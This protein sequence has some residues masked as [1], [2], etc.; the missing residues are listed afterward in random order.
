MI[1]IDKLKMALSFSRGLEQTLFDR[2]MKASN[3]IPIRYFATPEIFCTKNNELG[4]VIRVIGIPF[5]VQAGDELNHAQAT[6]SFV[7]QNLGDEFAVYVTQHRRR[8]MCQLEGEYPSGFARDFV[9]AYSAQFQQAHLF[10]NEIYIT[11]LLKAGSTRIKKGLAWLTQLNARQEQ[12][13][14]QAW[15]E[16]RL[17]KFKT[18]LLNLATALK[19]YSPHILAQR[20]NEGGLP[21]AELL[22][23][24]SILVNG[25]KKAF[26]YPYADIASFIPN[27]RLFFGDNTL[28]FQHPVKGHDR[29]G[30]LLSIKHYCPFTKPGLLNA[31][32]TTPFETITT[33][34][35]M[36]IDKQHALNLIETQIKRLIATQDA[37]RSQIA[38][39]ETA[40]DDLASGKISYGFHH[41]TVLIL[42][43]SLEDLEDKVSHVI[44]LYQDNRIAVV[45]E[46]L[47][48]EKAFWAQIPGNFKDIKRKAPISSHNFSC[49]CALHNYHTGYRD[50][51]HLGGALM[52][53]ETMSKTPFYFNLH[54]KASGRRDDLPEG[55]TVLI[56]PTN[57]GKTVIMSTIN[58]LMQKYQI[59]SF[60]FDRNYG[61]EIYVRA[62]GGVYHRLE[63]G[64]PTGWNPCQLTDTPKNRQF[65][66]DFLHVLSTGETTVLTPTDMNQIADV[67]D[68]IFTLPLDKRNLSNVASFFRLDF[69]GLTSLSRYLRLPDR[70]GRRGDRAYLFD[71]D[72]DHLNVNAQTMGFDMTHWLTE[73]GQ[74]PEALLPISMYLFHRIDA[75]L[76]GQLTG[77]YLDEG[78]QF[79]NQPYWKE[80]LEEYLVTWRKRNAFL[81]FAT[82]LPDKVA[83]SALAS[84]LIQNTATKIFLANP[85][86]KEKDYVGSFELTPR[87]YEIIKH[88]VPQSRYFLIK[89]GHEAAVARINLQGLE[90]HMTVLSGTDHTV[91][92]CE[93]ARQAKGEDPTLWLPYFY[94]RR[95]YA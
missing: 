57:A 91:R 80:K 19:S 27:V 13:Q 95:G 40:K 87:E 33:H 77:L 82:Q 64:I 94:E 3:Y 45:R 24:L 6:L 88:L 18:A 43:D 89:Q 47:N 56:G 17:R 22:S 68:R 84:A 81:F 65:L 10:V 39:L 72:V 61:M 42:S 46:T 31:L 59:R 78:W 4:A 74:P 14:Q 34:S 23:F 26:T 51:N 7:L 9:N 54:K 85:Q 15:L 86:A 69:G 29:F 79:L 20:P 32:L 28:H 49:F 83:N 30:A 16:Q 73:S 71:N 12:A 35:F 70:A 62:M 38:E 93:E 44:K 76:A 67:V 66:R 36:G 8:E 55:H 21:E 50:L 92:M 25:E 90:K 60:L 48:L 37:A 1:L 75:C 53:V 5:E 11:L 52:L 41:N 58:T 2:E 63:P